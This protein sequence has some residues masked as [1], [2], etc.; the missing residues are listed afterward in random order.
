METTLHS[1][2]HEAFKKSI[3]VS[4]ISG[5]LGSMSQEEKTRAANYFLLLID[6]FIDSLS[7]CR[8]NKV[9][10]SAVQGKDNIWYMCQEAVRLKPPCVFSNRQTCNG[11]L[12]SELGRNNR[13]RRGNS[14]DVRAL[15]VRAR[16]ARRRIKTYIEEIANE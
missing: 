9:F 13:R 6:A 4:F 12:F 8:T 15:I 16:V 3:P 2:N 10:L 7:K 14:L 1:V 5:S 11:C